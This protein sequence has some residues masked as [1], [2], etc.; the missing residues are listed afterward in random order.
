MS[1]NGLV[2]AVPRG[3][4]FEET[5]GWLER[6]G[7]STGEVRTNDR[8]LL[9][10][11]VGLIVR[12]QDAGRAGIGRFHGLFYPLRKRQLKALAVPEAISLWLK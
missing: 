6:L 5:L 7:V 11:D 9:F 4:L 1:S 10:E 12:D 8:R 2:I 3:A